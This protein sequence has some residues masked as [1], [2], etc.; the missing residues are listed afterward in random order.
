MK[1]LP[2]VLLPASTAP[3]SFSKIA[4]ETFWSDLAI[5]CQ[6]QKTPSRPT[7]LTLIVRWQ[8]EVQKD[9]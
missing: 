5:A 2:M 1:N 3:T 9:E 4:E 7:S 6:S 8:A